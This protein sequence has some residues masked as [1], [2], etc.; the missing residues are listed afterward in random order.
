MN[1][2]SLGVALAVSRRELLHQPIDLL[3]F[4]RKSEAAEEEADGGDEGE[5]AEVEAVDV[6]VHHFAVQSARHEWIK[7]TKKHHTFCR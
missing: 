5:L 6:G 3:R 2:S 4:A 1:V 7:L